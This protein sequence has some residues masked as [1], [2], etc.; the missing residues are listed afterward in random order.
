MD[1]PKP[2]YHTLRAIND[3]GYTHL[4]FCCLRCL[5]LHWVALDFAIHTAGPTA[6]LLD[7]ARRARCRLCGSHGAH[8]DVAEPPT[9]TNGPGYVAWIE[10]R[11][12]WILSEGAHL[13]TLIRAGVEALADEQPVT[14]HVEFWHR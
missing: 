7:L 13:Q 3:R 2:S 5:H 9:A 4:R 14:Q 10:R 1:A 12:R 6:G 11:M 8:V